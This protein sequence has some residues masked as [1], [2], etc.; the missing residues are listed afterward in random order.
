ME[1]DWD[2]LVDELKA[3][4]R[5]RSD[6]QLAHYLGLIR[7]QVSAW[8]CGKTKLGTLTKVK[9]MDAL[10]HHN[11]RSMMASL[12]PEEGRDAAI[13]LHEALIARVSAK[14]STTGDSAADR[15]S[16]AS[17]PNL[18]LAPASSDGAGAYNPSPLH[19]LT[20]VG[21]SALR[22]GRPSQPRSSADDRDN[23]DA[24]RDGKR[25]LGR[26][27]DGWQGRL[28]RGSTFYWRRDR[29]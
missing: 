11:V 10:G 8:R 6:A 28:T 2:A 5:F 27:C 26:N 20:A 21:T 13:Q 24:L 19:G 3:L 29:S 12:F 16:D 14:E 18:L 17:S 1:H 9:I 7:A 4:G 15:I 22:A 25:R 23:L